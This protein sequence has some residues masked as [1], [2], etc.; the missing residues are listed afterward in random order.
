M[1]SLLTF[2]KNM[3]IYSKKK[4]YDLLNLNVK[5]FKTLNTLYNIIILYQ[6]VFYA[7]NRNFLI[8][9]FINEYFMH[10]MKSLSNNY[11]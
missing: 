4:H 2:L 7:Q 6:Y 8:F 9:Y 3:N 10:P 11:L 5:T 1:L